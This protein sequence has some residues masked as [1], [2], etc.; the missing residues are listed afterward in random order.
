MVSDA[1]AGLKVHGDGSWNVAGLDEDD[2]PGVSST[3]RKNCADGGGRDERGMRN[4]DAQPNLWE[5]HPLNETPC[6]HR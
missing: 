5:G 3:G 1:G 6:Y 4:E 2:W